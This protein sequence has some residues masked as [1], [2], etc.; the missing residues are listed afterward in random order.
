MVASKII[1]LAY[2]LDMSG[3]VIG[4]MKGKTRAF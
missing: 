4:L 1:G 3:L 2:V